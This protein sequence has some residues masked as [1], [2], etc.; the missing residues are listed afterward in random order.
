[1]KNKDEFRIL[2]RRKCGVIASRVPPLNTP[3]LLSQEIDCIEDCFK[4]THQELLDRKRA[5]VMSI[6]FHRQ[7]ILD[8]RY[9][10]NLINHFFTHE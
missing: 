10:I 2:T 6:E 1:M 4:H 5:L 8:N 7:K 9:E 3:A